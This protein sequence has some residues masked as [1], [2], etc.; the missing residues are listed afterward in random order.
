MDSDPANALQRLER[1]EES[2]QRQQAE[3]NRRQQEIITFLT[4]NLPQLSATLPNNSDSAPRLTPEPE[5]N[6]AKERSPR[7]KAA[8][9]SDFDGSR[10][11]GRTFLNSCH[12][13][14]QLSERMFANDQQKIHWALTYCK[15]GRAAK[16][17]DR[18]LRSELGGTPRYQTW[19]EFTD[20]FT[21]KFC[22]S[23]EQVRALTKLEGDSWYQR[24][25]T[26]DEYIDTFEDLAE[27]GGL[28]PNDPGLVMKFRRG[29]TKDI[30]DKV[31]EMQGAPELDDLEGWKEAARHFYQNQEANRAFG[32][33]I[34]TSASVPSSAPTRGLVSAAPGTFPRPFPRFSVPPVPLP[35][36]FPRFGPKPEVAPKPKSDDPIP[37]EV[38]AS[39]QR[40][41]TPPVCFRCQQPG[42]LAKECPH[43]FD[44][45][46]MTQ[47][48]RKD[49]L[50]QLLVEADMAQVN[51]IGVSTDSALTSADQSEPELADFHHSS[52]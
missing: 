9:P 20:D 33:S 51:A 45:R 3:A 30:Q 38:D 4:Q 25:S 29:L 39:K 8:P 18:I 21:L 37:M 40:R 14:L 7:V 22:E 31:A 46:A 42:H 36:P 32:K 28:T 16:F 6:T 50:E 17:A 34:R 41:L 23:Q 47:D 19:K 15:S 5:V 2:F 27:L 48:E 12:L 1:L 24:T 43:R 10:K 35:S 26:V 13:Y 52:E 11:N 49:L 44:V